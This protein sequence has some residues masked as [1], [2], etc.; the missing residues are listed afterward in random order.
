M[1]FLAAFFALFAAANAALLRGPA[2]FDSCANIECGELT[3]PGGFDA[4][5]HDGHC[6]PVCENPDVDIS[7]PP[8]GPKGSSGGKLSAVAECPNVWCFP[9]MCE[10]PKQGKCCMEC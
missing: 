10:A 5:H 9:V 4:V 8:T 7:K 1:K 2:A 3:C 6:C